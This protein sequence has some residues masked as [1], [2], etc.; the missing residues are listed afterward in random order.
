MPDTYCTTCE[1]TTAH[2]AVMR[3]SIKEE[4]TDT[5]VLQSF[6]LLMSHLINGKHYYKMEQQ[7][8][9][10]ACNCQSISSENHSI[11]ARLANS[12]VHL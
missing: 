10:R 1:R 5:G 4:S 7:L 11:Y 6:Q 3:R 2:K 9:C 8:F 12:E